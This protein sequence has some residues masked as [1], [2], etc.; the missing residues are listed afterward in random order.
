MFIHNW[1]T[2]MMVTPK[3]L[4]FAGHNLSEPW[5]IVFFLIEQFVLFRNWAACPKVYLPNQKN[6]MLWQKKGEL[7]GELDSWK[8]YIQKCIKLVHILLFSDPKGTL[9]IIF[10]MK[11]FE[12]KWKILKNGGIGYF[13]VTCQPAPTEKWAG[14]WGFVLREAYFVILTLYQNVINYFN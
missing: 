5:C 3:V 13:H 9:L 14:H 7:T 1:V 10:V 11:E 8:E 12:T 4:C 2:F 6:P